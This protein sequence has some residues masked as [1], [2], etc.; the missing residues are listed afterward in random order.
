MITALIL[1]IVILIVG[2]IFSLFPTI[3][4]LPTIAGFDI[5]TALVQGVGFLKRFFQTFWIFQSILN[6]FLTLTG[7]YVVKL[8]AQFFLGSR[9]PR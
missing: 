3:D 6:G 8:I 2:S 7:Y 1:N 5:D 9:A 4:T